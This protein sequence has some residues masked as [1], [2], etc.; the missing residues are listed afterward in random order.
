MNAKEF[1]TVAIVSMIIGLV[2]QTEPYQRQ[3]LP[4]SY[5]Q[6]KPVLEHSTQ[7][8]MERQQYRHTVKMDNNDRNP[9]N[10]KGKKDEEA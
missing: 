7:A 4:V 1:F 8:W 6:L 2:T 10:D 9:G 5:L 3:P